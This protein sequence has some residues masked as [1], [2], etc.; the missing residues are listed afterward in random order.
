LLSHLIVRLHSDG[1]TSI[2]AMGNCTVSGGCPHAVELTA[3]PD[4]WACWKCLTDS[5]EVRLTHYVCRRCQLDICGS[6][7]EMMGKRIVGAANLWQELKSD[8]DVQK[9]NGFGSI[10]TS[11]LNLKVPES[12]KG[13]IAIIACGSY[14]PPTTAHFR[15][16]EDAKD[17]AQ[18]L[19]IH[20]LGGFMSPCHIGY[21]KKSLCANYH[22]VNML[23]SA[24][25][26]ND[27]IAVDPWEC[28]QEAWTP[29]AQVIDRYQDELDK[30][31]SKGHLNR[32]AKAALLG[33]A[34]LVESF[35]AIGKDGK[36]VWTPEHVEKIVS[37]G[38]V[39]IA[40]QGFVLDDVIKSNKILSRFKDNIYVVV[41]PVENNISSTLIRKN[42]AENKSVKYIVH[43]AV[44]DYIYRQRL[45]ELPNWQRC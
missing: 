45:N 25:Q 31:H 11:K 44:I 6:C 13:A 5:R 15:I 36:P 40:R 19:G 38:V 43:D 1:P 28:A 24:L 21:G 33:G 8:E 16:L 18:S 9:L 20:V 32:P 22:R 37:R 17:C 35:S 4:D 12:S 34:D 7:V 26:F 29:T 27:W 30:L 2:S 10:P 41:P 3:T 42:L 14:S 39:C 23:G